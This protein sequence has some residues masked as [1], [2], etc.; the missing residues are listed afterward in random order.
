MLDALRREIAER[1]IGD[2]EQ[3]LQHDQQD[4]DECNAGY[5]ADECAACR[6]KCAERCTPHNELEAAAENPDE[7]SEQHAEQHHQHG[8]RDALRHADCRFGYAL[9][10]TVQHAFGGFERGLLFKQLTDCRHDHPLRDIR[11]GVFGGGNRRGDHADAAEHAVQRTDQS[12]PG[13]EPHV[14][15]QHG[16]EDQVRRVEQ[17]RRC[18]NNIVDISYLHALPRIVRNAR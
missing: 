9:P 13:T 4:A 6:I 16:N 3:P 11:R 12:T 14:G 15:Q 1:R 8:E 7:P 18:G 5:K 17:L 2:R 10:Q